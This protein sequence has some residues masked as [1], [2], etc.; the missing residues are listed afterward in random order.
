MKRFA[1]LL[2]ALCMI[3]FLSCM[4]ATETET[5]DSGSS[6]TVKST[7]LPGVDG[8]LKSASSS[9]TTYEYTYTEC[10]YIESRGDEEPATIAGNILIPKAVTEGETFPAIIFANSWALEEHEYLAQAIHFAKKGYIV[11]SYSSRGWGVSGGQVA[12]GSPEDWADFSAV[13][14]WLIANSPVD[15]SNIGVCGI[16]LGGGTALN[17]AAHDERVKT[18]VGISAWTD[19][20][21]HMWSEETPKLVWG[22]LLVITGTILARL[23]PDIYSIYYATLSNSNISWLKEWCGI[24]SPLTFVENINERDCPI[25]I[26]NGMEDYLFTPDTVL[27]FFNALTVSHKRADLSLGTH[28]T[29]EATGILGLP[30][31]VFNNVDMWFDYWLK[32][33]DTGIISDQE[34]SAVVTMQLKN[35]LNR[36]EFDTASLKKSDTEYS[37]PP[38]NVEEQTFYC[39]ERT[40]FTNGK[41]KTSMN[42]KTSTDSMYSGLLSGSTAGAVIFP[43]LEQLGVGVTTSMLLLNRL[44]SVAWE[45]SAFGTDKKIRGASEAKL[46][47]SLSYKK[48]QIII[49]LYDVDKWGTATYITHGFHTFWDATPGEVM[50]VTVPITTTAYDIPAGH[51]LAMVI[52]TSDPLYSKPSLRP[53]NI[54]YYYGKTADTQVMLTVPFEN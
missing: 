34:R 4:D 41:L 14:D 54:K 52:D 51:H 30:N 36:V 9:T 29:P 1:L 7:T 6:A 43:I 23:D 5:T 16:S 25:Y 49:Y 53:F 26:A 46:R 39:A 8:T 21:T 19:L 20:E 13:V 47:L 37:W 22:S 38:N 44:E 31:Y 28:F 50:D 32:G 2:S 35:S 45:S 17:A 27:N 11:L 15:E 40:L 48:G 18:A 24:R 12:L 42:T 3:F 10:V 33:I